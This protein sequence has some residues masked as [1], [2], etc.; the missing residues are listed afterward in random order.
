MRVLHLVPEVVDDPA[1]YYLGSTKDVACRTRYLR[2]RSAA[3]VRLPFRRGPHGVADALAGARGH[4]PVD[5][6]LVETVPLDVAALRQLT[7][8]PVAVRSQNAELL[9]RW[10]WAR[11]ATRPLDRLRYASRGV[12]GLAREVGLGGTT[13]LPISDWEAA[14]Y[15]RRFKTAA[16]VDVVPFYLTPEYAEP[17]QPD[18]PSRRPRLL[19]L[20]TTSP[21]PLI[22]DG[23]RAFDALARHLGDASVSLAMTG[24]VPRGVRLD[25]RI[26]V[27]GMVASPI[28]ALREASHVV[29]PS[30][31]GHGFKTKILEALVAGCRVLVHERLHR[32][33]PPEVRAACD[34]LDPA[35]LDGVRRLLAAGPTNVDAMAVNEALRRRSDE[36]M[37]RLLARAVS[38]T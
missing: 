2:E 6:V 28:E 14:H 5:L 38:S 21:N 16:R 34:P 31:L 18:H 7:G 33:L 29:L 22:D 35:D 30:P 15:Y 17:V 37:D 19:M 32:R 11:A 8:V 4:G 13:V 26:D 3:V 23:V 1:Q 12:R 25:D 24:N 20:G 27:L 9:H 36:A 10:D